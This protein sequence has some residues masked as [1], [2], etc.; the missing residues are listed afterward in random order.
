M[1]KKWGIPGKMREYL[2]PGE[3]AAKLPKVPLN[4]N[5]LNAWDYKKSRYRRIDLYPVVQQ[6]GVPEAAEASPS[7]SPSPTASLTPTPTTSL[8][9]V[10]YG[11]GFNN[12]L[13]S[14]L[15]E[16]SS[17]FIGGLFTTY[18]G[19]SASRII[20]L[21]YDGSINTTFSSGTGFQNNVGAIKRYDA[22]SLLIGGSFTNY[23]GI[24]NSVAFAKIDNNGTFLSGFT[25]ANGFSGTVNN[26]S[27]IELTNDNKIYFGGAF[28]LFSGISAGRI[29]RLNSDLTRDSSFE[30][31]TGFNSTV[32]AIT[33]QT[34]DKILLGGLFTSYS[35]ISANRL[36]RLNTNGS[37]DTSFNIGTG[38]SNLV[39]A[40]TI[41]NDGKILVGGSFDTFSGISAGRI[42]RLNIDGSVDNT[43]NSGT[44]FGG[45]VSVISIGADNKIYVGGAFTTYN[46]TNWNR[47]I[48]LNSD[49]SVDNTF[50]SAGADGS[51]FEIGFLDNGRIVI[52]GSFT[53]YN[54]YLANRFAILN[55]NGGLIDCTF[56]TP[57]PTPTITRTPT[58][59]PT[60]TTTATVTPTTTTTP[61]P[62]I[63]PS[64]T[65]TCVEYG[66]T[67]G[68]VNPIVQYN[69][70]YYLA[71]TFTTF[72]G[73]SSSRFVRLELNGDVDT[74]FS[75]N[76]GTGFGNGNPTYFGFQSDGKIVCGG[77]F[78]SFDGNT[79]GRIVRL[80]SDGS[81]DSSFSAGTG[82]NAAVLAL[83]VLSNDK[84]LVGGSFFDYD[85]NAVE[86]I[87]RLNADGSLDNTFTGLP[88]NAVQGILVQSDG[89]YIISGA[90]QNIDSNAALFIGRLNSDGSYDS[91]FDSSNGFNNSVAELALQPDGKI[92]CG[93]AQ[94]TSYSGVSAN[95]IIRLNSDATIDTS[96]VYGTGFNAQ[97]LD[98][99]LQND[100]KILASGQF[101]T[102]SG[103]SNYKLIRLNSDGSIDGTF[104]NGLTFSNG[105]LFMD[106]LPS[107]RIAIG[108]IDM[109]S[110]DG[111]IVYNW[112]IL[113]ENG[114]LIDCTITPISPTPTNTQ[115]ITPTMT[116]TPS[117]TQTSTPT[118]TVTITPTSSCP[119]TTQY[120]NSEVVDGN[121]IRFTLWNDSGYTSQ[122]SSLCD[123]ILS[124]TML[125][126][127]GTTYTDAR[128]F[129]AAEHQFQENFTSVLQPGE[130]II[131]HTI[132]SVNT[133]ACTCPVIVEFVFVSP[134]PTPTVTQTPTPTVTPTEP[135]D[136]Y[137]FEECNNP[138]N[139][140]RYEN[141]P[142]SLVLGETYEI[143]GGAGFNGFATVVTDTS[144]GSL[145]AG[146]G[147]TFT[148]SSCPTPTPTPTETPTPTPSATP[149]TG[150][151]FLLQEDSGELLQEDGGNILL[152]Q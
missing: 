72:S 40:I 42:I 67:N 83:R 35:G 60:I 100:G 124:G 105:Q 145:Y 2:S 144:S 45:T 4:A 10:D 53:S 64:T 99:H 148:L 33:K 135:Y 106:E 63:T 88:D 44:G 69:N 90:F 114:G 51:V 96:F 133:S 102:Y 65:Q 123:Y 41:Q 127:S 150:S 38:F 13:S 1:P 46:A 125:G 11:T 137:Q 139:I 89:K 21:N 92:V 79:A 9:C 87:V 119:V 28:S 34:D 78:T 20:S 109:S 70:Q 134:T 50:N 52:G 141:V 101:T 75:S 113:N 130:T 149:S 95:R 116:Q 82:F 36:I 84:I 24:S 71:G 31:G 29:I 7:V 47:I 122:A 14:L 112:A 104:V 111:S 55:E 6:G 108:G 131:Y 121:K 142:G 94:F 25:A 32:I 93:G 117:V 138:S 27:A 48:R 143:T 129:P 26:I 91:S 128:T 58:Q 22:N 23:Q 68:Y 152:E 62:T 43:F 30:I 37:I 120:M 77:N 3:Q 8:P 98:V 66:T 15:I 18:S 81:Y 76:M 39:N 56:S 151:N 97:V 61:T 103:A 80:N 17:I 126:S 73:V 115:T 74:T 110:Y 132:L 147:V 136:V 107:G 86:Y 146:A 16:P 5:P 49:G 19:A 12:S 140:F 85:G 54:G 59:T 57:T 118:P